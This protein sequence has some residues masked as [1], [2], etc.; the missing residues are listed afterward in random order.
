[1]SYFQHTRP[2]FSAAFG[3]KADYREISIYMQ[4]ITENILKNA[5]ANSHRCCQFTAQ[6][7]ID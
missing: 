1:M 6:L 3:M 5:N 7:P 2:C 4:I